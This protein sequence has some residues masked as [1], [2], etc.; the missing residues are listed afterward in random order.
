MAH[1]N[2][3]RTG[4]VETESHLAQHLIVPRAGNEILRKLLMS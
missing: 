1:Q 2:L 3:S 4:Q